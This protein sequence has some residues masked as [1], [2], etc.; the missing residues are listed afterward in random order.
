MDAVGGQQNHWSSRFGLLMA[1]VGFA[2]GI[3]NIWRISDLTGENGGAEF[4]L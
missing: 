3:G 2:V 1:S 4:G